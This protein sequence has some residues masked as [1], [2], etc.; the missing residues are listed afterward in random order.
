MMS[1]PYFLDY[2]YSFLFGGRGFAVSV[3]SNSVD[4][5]RGWTNLQI[6]FSETPFLF[7]I[8]TMDNVQKCEIS[9][10]QVG[11]YED[12]RLLGYRAM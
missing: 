2:I 8:R 1:Q 10:S 5:T 6:P 4:F 12:E 11:E 3:G 7:K 9:G